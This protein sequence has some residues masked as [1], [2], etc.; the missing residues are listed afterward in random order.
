MR[1]AEFRAGQ[2][3]RAGPY[4]VS[5]AEIIDFA[6]RYDPQWFHTDPRAAAA[7]H[8]GG[9]VASGWLTCAIAMRLIVEVA[10]AGSE[11]LAS[12]GIEQ[13]KWPAAVRPGDE[14]R[15]TATVLDARHANSRPTLGI[16]RWRWQ[17]HNQQHVEVVD[18]VATSLFNLNSCSS[19]QKA[20]L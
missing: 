5:E 14:L 11:S 17:L 20:P 10:L 16:L 4:K 6:S 2:E 18:L 12:P 7:H 8:F 19:K 13:I 9:L 1:F 15:L 3:L